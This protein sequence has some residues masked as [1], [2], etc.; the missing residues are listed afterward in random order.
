MHLPI[1]TVAAINNTHAFKKNGLVSLTEKYH[2]TIADTDAKR[3]RKRK[4]QRLTRKLYR[5]LFLFLSCLPNLIL[6]QGVYCR[7]FLKFQQLAR[8]RVVYGVITFAP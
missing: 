5:K 3:N 7:F 2:N 1:Q 4:K 8:E 6:L